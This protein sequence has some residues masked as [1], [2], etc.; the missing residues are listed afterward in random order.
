ML[1]LHSQPLNCILLPLQQS[2]SQIL[3]M[4]FKEQHIRIG[5]G[6]ETHQ[7]SND[8]I[9]LTLCSNILLGPGRIGLQYIQSRIVFAHTSIV[10]WKLFKHSM[11]LTECNLD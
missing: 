11:Q 10:P 2:N 9:E 8:T 7:W 6:Q 5:I 3:G 1:D 4:Q